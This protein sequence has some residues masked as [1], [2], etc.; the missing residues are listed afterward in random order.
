MAQNNAGKVHSQWLFIQSISLSQQ[1]CL[2]LSQKPLDV[3]RDMLDCWHWRIQIHM[4][5]FEFCFCL[6]KVNSQVWSLDSFNGHQP[7]T[8][9]EYCL[10]SL[11]RCCCISPHNHQSCGM[12]WLR[13]W[14][15]KEN[16]LFS[17]S[18]SIKSTEQ[19]QLVRN[20]SCTRMS[21]RHMHTSLFL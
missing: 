2:P 1:I 11:F 7:I 3:W 19:L 8:G 16:L 4:W 12:Q 15:G 9:F 13:H 10:F 20:T 14:R 6:A 17:A 21:R 5:N 18:S